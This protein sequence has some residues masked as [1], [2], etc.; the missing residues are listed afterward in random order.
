WNRTGE[1]YLTVSTRG[2]WELRIQNGAGVIVSV[3][4]P[5]TLPSFSL[6]IELTVYPRAVRPG[7]TVLVQW[8]RKKVKEIFSKIDEETRTLIE[9][10]IKDDVEN[11]DEGFEK[12]IA[13]QIQS[14][15]TNNGATN[16]NNS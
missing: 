12:Y 14:Q 13:S 15:S 3:S 10:A 16:N 6:P 5:F 1:L 11:P 9:K 4:K 2:T 7:G 8:R